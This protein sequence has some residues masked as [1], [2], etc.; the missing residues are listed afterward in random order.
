MALVS[1]V[2]VAC[3]AAEISKEAQEKAVNNA[4]S[5][6]EESTHDAQ[7]GVDPD[8]RPWPAPYYLRD[9]LRRVHPY[10][11]TYNTYVK[12]RWIDRGILDVFSSEFRDRSYE[13]YVRDE[14]YNS[15]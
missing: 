9:G 1:D 8:G 12:G 14:I 3:P 15:H 10:F 4:A 7:G 13:Y 5:L 6:T 2:R 11:Y